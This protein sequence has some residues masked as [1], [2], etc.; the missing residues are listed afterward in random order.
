MWAVVKDNW[1]TMNELFPSNTIVRMLHG[2][3]A[4]SDPQ[5]ADSVLDFFDGRP[6]PQGQKQLDQ[7]LERLGVNRRFRLRVQAELSAALS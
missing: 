6:L 2:V 5:T 3:R 7:H 4:L 1:D